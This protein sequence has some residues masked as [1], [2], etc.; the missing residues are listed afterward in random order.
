[1]P[2]TNLR[3]E[4][5]RAA[6]EEE[7][8]G[9][10]PIALFQRWFDEAVRAPEREPNAMTLATADAAGQPCARIVLCK[11]FDREGFVFYTNY[12][13]RKGRE[14]AQNPLACLLFFWSRTERQVRIDGPVERVS[15]AESDEY[16]AQRP[17]AARIGAWAS[18]QSQTIGGR[19]E[20]ERRFQEAERRFAGQPAPPRPEQWG[21]YRLRPL[22]IEFWQGRPSR[23][24]DRLLYTRAPGGAGGAPC[25]PWQRTRL[26]P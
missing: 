26:A 2:K 15:A 7:Q 10:D 24:H 25:G 9:G 22:A 11:E 23:L 21:G 12:G 18:P 19:E 6:L 8:A 1:M 16:F 13:S 4:Y 17:L 14:L 5:E 3:T 20:L